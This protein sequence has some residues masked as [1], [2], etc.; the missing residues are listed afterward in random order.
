M[1]SAT[2]IFLGK[3]ILMLLIIGAMI[4]ILM[5][6]GHLFRIDDLNSKED[7]LKLKDDLD[8]DETVV[9]EKSVFY[10]F[11]VHHEKGN[12]IKD[13]DKKPGRL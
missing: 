5:G 7:D 1:I 13:N 8:K 3:V 2:L 4:M 12:R 10:N 11:L 6:I 9:S